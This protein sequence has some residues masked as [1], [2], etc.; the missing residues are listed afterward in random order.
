MANISET[1]LNACERGDMQ[2]FKHLLKRVNINEKNENGYSGLALAVRNGY[3]DI[4]Y[5]LIQEEADINSVNE[6]G[7]SILFLA[8]WHNREEIVTILL[9]SGALVNV[10][11]NRG[12]TPLMISVY[13]NYYSIVQ[14]LLDHGADPNHKDCFGKKA[15]ER[16]KSSEVIALLQKFEQYNI[17]EKRLTPNTL[18]KIMN[19]SI[20]SIQSE[21]KPVKKNLYETKKTGKL[22]EEV[23][24]HVKTQTRKIEKELSNEWSEILEHCLNEEISQAEEILIEEIEAFVLKNIQDNYVKLKENCINAVDEAYR[25][26]GFKV[27]PSEIQINFVPHLSLSRSGRGKRSIDKKRLE[28]DDMYFDSSSTDAND[29]RL[30]V[31]KYIE[32]SIENLASK[33]EKVSQDVILAEIPQRIMKMKNS[34]A[35]EIQDFIIETGQ[36][37]KKNLEQLAEERGRELMRG[38]QDKSESFKESFS[39]HIKEERSGKPKYEENYEF[40][41]SLA[42]NYSS[43]KANTTENHNLSGSFTRENKFVPKKPGKKDEKA[44]IPRTDVSSILQQ[45]LKK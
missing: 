16:A 17:P 21:S 28:S 38:N 30:E 20:S 5:E 25:N 31:V 37:M 29:L 34:I 8:C 45:F 15:A 7:Q 24:N 4:V 13:H 9:G 1:F 22:Q 19:S 6:A 44:P 32:R 3:L 10:P 42:N 26:K 39:G 27:T 41:E 36:L 40:I 12:W 33:F 11:D 23:E 35:A 43:F 14:I 18:G 2:T